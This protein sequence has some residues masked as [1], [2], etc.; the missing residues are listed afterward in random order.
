MHSRAGPRTGMQMLGI[1]INN[2]T[3]NL[4]SGATSSFS[5]VSVFGASQYVGGRRWRGESIYLTDL[6]L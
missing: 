2:S 5:F 1:I 4:I 6:H 3:N